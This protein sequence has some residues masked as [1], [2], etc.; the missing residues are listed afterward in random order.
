MLYKRSWIWLCTIFSPLS[1]P[2]DCA[3]AGALK[4]LV[5]SS[6]KSVTATMFPNSTS[7][8]DKFEILNLS[9]EAMFETSS[10]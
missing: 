7:L 4:E 6:Y 10:L 9:K 2:L 8:C 3:T 1:W 5:G